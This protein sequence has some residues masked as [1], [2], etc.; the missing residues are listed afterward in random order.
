MPN[1]ESEKELYLKLPRWFLYCCCVAYILFQGTRNRANAPV[2]MDLLRIPIASALSVALRLNP[3][4][5][6]Q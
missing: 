3:L 1:S 6:K 5:N 2:L 4:T